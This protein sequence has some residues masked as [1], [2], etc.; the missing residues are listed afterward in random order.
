M[1]H[2]TRLINEANEAMLPLMANFLRDYPEHSAN[3][4]AEA[5]YS[6]DFTALRVQIDK[7]ELPQHK[8]RFEEFLGTNLIGDTG[9][10]FTATLAGASPTTSGWTF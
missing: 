9:Q 2:Q 6:G 3:L 4:R 1:S 5:Q 10:T 8:Q 7:E